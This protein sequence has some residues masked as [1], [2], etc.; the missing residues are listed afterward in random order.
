MKDL[1]WRSAVDEASL[2]QLTQHLHACDE[3]FV[4]PLGDRVHI[5]DY[6]RKIQLHAVRL[7]AWH[8]QDLI[9]LVAMYCNDQA[10]GQAHV[11]SVSVLPTWTRQGIAAQ[12]MRQAIAYARKATMACVTLDVGAAND[13]AIALYEGLGFARRAH[14]GNMLTMR[15]DFSPGE[16]S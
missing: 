4:P 8:A 7:E 12:L 11:T 3:H 2:A 5:D 13:A 15:L 9:A 10:S 14:A 6:A 1:G 16:H